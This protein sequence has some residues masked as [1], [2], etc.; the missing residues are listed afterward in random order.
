MSNE[1]S[2]EAISCYQQAIARLV[3]SGPNQPEFKG[4]LQ[5][6]TAAFGERQENDAPLYVSVY[7]P[8]TLPHL[9]RHFQ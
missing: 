3:Q 1:F 2:Q 4:L 5:E 9:Q 8:E 7:D 6:A